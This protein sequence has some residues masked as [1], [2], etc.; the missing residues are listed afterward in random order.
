MGGN[1]PCP[2]CAKEAGNKL[3]DDV[4]D[5]AVKRAN[6]AEK[7]RDDLRAQVAVL[8]KEIKLG[9][10]CTCGRRTHANHCP[11]SNSLVVD[12]LERIRAL[13]SGGS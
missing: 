7:E 2:W 8:E 10:P 13:K 5:H 9:L 4:L 3:A 6:S 12:F 11:R 1:P